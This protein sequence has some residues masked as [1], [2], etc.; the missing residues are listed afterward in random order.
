MSLSLSLSLCVGA[1]VQTLP[2][3]VV[4]MHTQG[5][6]VVVGDVQES[7]HFLKYKSQDN[8]ARP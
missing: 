1:C 2:H 3:A 5:D 7:V 4:T 6:R 8:Q